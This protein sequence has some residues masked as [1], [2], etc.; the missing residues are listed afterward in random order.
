[1]TV[2]YGKSYL[3]SVGGNISCRVGDIVLIT[4]SG[5]TKFLITMDDISVV[6]LDGKLLNNVR[7]SSE[8]PVHLAIY[9]KREDVNCVIHAHPL[10]TI[11]VSMIFDENFVEETKI[12]PESVVYTG[13]VKI[14][15]YHAPGNEAA[16]MVE[17]VIG[18]SDII[19]IK[20]HGVFSTGRS[21]DEALARL[22]VLEENSKLI[23][24]LSLMVRDYNLLDVQKVISEK[25]ALSSEE[26]DKL[27]KIYK[28]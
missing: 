4:P 24:Y 5:K 27:L 26:A 6:S 21:I 14:I 7:P 12:T 16:M 10:F 20:N 22:E 11:I 2:L 18:E 17:K 13:R 19:I 23:Y 3:S 15:S 9:K 25:Y 28:K 1:M 8:L